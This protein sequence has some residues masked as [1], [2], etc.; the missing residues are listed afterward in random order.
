[1][2]IFEINKYSDFVALKKSWYD[3]LE[4]SNHNIFSTWEWLSLWWKHFGN[5]K[6]LL[7]LLAEDNGRLIGIAPLMYS[8]YKMFGLRM[9]KIEFIGAQSSDYNDF[10]L[11]K[12][13]EEC[14]KLFIKYLYNLRENWDCIELTDIPEGARCLPFLKKNSKNMKISYKCCY[15][16]LPKSYEAFFKSLSRNQRKYLRKNERKIG[17]DFRVK[18]IEH[19]QD[20]SI[21]EGMDNLF[22]LHQ[23]R[24]MSR[25]FLGAFADKK[26][27]NFHID[28][29]KT[30]SR[31]NW[32]E[33][34]TL[35]LSGNPVSTFYGFKYKSK[36]YEYLNGW[37]P[38]YSRYSLAN[39]HRAYMIRKFIQE[40]LVE[41][42]FLRGGEEY[43]YRWNA[44]TRLNRQ[45]LIIKK[46]LLADVE[47][48]LYEKYWL[49]GN[50][51]KSL[52]KI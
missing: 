33:L 30:F 16:S 13:R 19:S 31:K 14:L 3:L 20:Q 1:M 44:T 46:G 51:V 37:D 7:L 11:A 15:T 50:R 5:D 18:Y 28:V 21:D 2:K 10:I 6:K 26:D 17:N 34:I 49:Q 36:F 32:L 52:L 47:N 40:G 12:K 42:D 4:R 22:L 35:N 41:H 23:K 24:W 27:R 43:K 29:A 48:W 45:A 8:V 25:G 39:I 9:G 38:A